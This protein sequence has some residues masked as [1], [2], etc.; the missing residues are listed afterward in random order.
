MQNKILINPLIINILKD[1]VSTTNPLLVQAHQ[2][3]F[4]I[5]T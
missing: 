2:S 1:F 4:I 5:K 3:I